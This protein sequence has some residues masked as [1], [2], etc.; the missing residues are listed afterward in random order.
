MEIATTELPHIFLPSAEVEIPFS[1]RLIIV[2]P[3]KIYLS[4]GVCN[5][6]L[7][8]EVALHPF[9]FK[10]FIIWQDQ[11]PL[12]RKLTHTHALHLRHHRTPAIPGL[13]YLE[14][15]DV[16]HHQRLL[17]L[18]CTDLSQLGAL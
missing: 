18:W 1:M 16:F 7:A 11:K 12:P 15:F 4:V 5:L 13:T 6:G 17:S 9:S 14:K 8:N 2:D 3:S 10:F